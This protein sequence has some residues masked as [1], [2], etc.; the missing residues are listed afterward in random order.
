MSGSGRTGYLGLGSN[1]GDRRAHLQAAVDE[2]RRR[3]VEISP[4]SSTYDTEPVGEMLDQPP[5]LNACVRAGTTLEPHALLDTCKAV[6]RAVG[7]ETGGRRHGPRTVDVDIL[8]LGSST[9][10]S[11]RLRLPHREVTSRRFVLIPLLELDPDLR[12]PD[13][14]R[15]ADALST[16]GAGQSVRRVGPPLV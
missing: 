12:L 5:F 2:L 13:G 3:G 1:L 9:L 15:A 11:E 14:T 10:H 6:E 4:C 8:L 7:R 16:L